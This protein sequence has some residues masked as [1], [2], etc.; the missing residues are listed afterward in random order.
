M[1]PQAEHV[2]KSFNT[3]VQDQ[4]EPVE[5]C[6]RNIYEMVEMCNC[7]NGKNDRICE[8]FVVGL[9]DKEI[10]EELQV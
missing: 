2:Y 4:E 5:S 8:R 6:V 10:S 7:G 1:G 9:A 3:R